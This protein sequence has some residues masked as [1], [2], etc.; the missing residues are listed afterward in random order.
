MFGLTEAVPNPI[1]RFMSLLSSPRFCKY[2]A[3]ATC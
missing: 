3:V 2:L 1:M